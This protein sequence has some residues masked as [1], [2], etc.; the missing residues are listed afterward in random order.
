MTKTFKEYITES[1]S[2][3]FSYRI[4]LAGDYGPSDATY[5]ENI[6]GKYGVQSV[7][8]FNRTPIQEEPLDFKNRNIKYPVEVSSCDVTLQY[9]INER[10]L[11]VWVAVHL[12]VSPENV[13]I[14]PTEGPRQLEDNLL[15]DRI[16]NDKDRY[17][18][19]DEAELTKEEQAHY[20][21]EQQF[22][23]LNELGLYGEEFNEKFIAEL[24]KI[25]PS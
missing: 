23:D 18:D 21:D 6:L 5:I 17:A 1:F 15:K 10:L 16:E 20:E 9:P 24:K 3:S 19:M 22:L 14:Q 7:S 13:L 8:S 12:G 4:K 25:I 11:E 2:K